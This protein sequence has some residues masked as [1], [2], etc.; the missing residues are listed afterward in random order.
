MYEVGITGEFA[1]AHA[2]RD[3]Q[4]PCERLH[5][6]NYQV[7]VVVQGKAL[8]EK[9]LLIDFRQLRAWLQEELAQLD[10]RLLNEVPAFADI[11]P[12]SEAL[13]RYLYEQLRPRLA[14]RGLRLARVTVW[15]TARSWAAYIPDLAEEPR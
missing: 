8:D 13:A 14:E 4:G 5:G 6:H 15:E 11:S 12:T 10:H 7:E 3:Y 2:L 1:A 9:H